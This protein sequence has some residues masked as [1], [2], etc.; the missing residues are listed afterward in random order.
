MFDV[1]CVTLACRRMQ[2]AYTP[3]MLQMPTDAQ[4][5]SYVDLVHLTLT[6]SSA[7]VTTTQLQM[8][9]LPNLAGTT[10]QNA[11]LA[12]A[13]LAGICVRPGPTP[14]STLRDCATAAHL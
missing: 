12:A 11:Q 10:V 13:H 3:S 8:M 9:N 14:P 4:L 6:A 5:L 7:G 1:A 2:A